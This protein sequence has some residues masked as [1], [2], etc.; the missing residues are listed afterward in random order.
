M[1]DPE[2]R[3]MVCRGLEDETRLDESGLFLLTESGWGRFCSQLVAGLPCG[4]RRPL[5]GP[6]VS[7]LGLPLPKPS[8]FGSRGLHG[9]LYPQ[10]PSKG[11]PPPAPDQL[12]LDAS[13]SPPPASLARFRMFSQK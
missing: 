7:V 5:A 10:H 1:L 4:F 12:L 2:H 11:L 8:V 13:D 6:A 9:A 3:A